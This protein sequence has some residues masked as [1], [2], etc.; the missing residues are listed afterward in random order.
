MN[1][2]RYEMYSKRSRAKTAP[3]IANGLVAKAK[4]EWDSE[5]FNME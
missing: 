1:I 5:E 4:G 3:R 2:D